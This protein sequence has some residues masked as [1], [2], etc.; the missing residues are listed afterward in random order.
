MSNNAQAG[1]LVAQ[2]WN[3]F[4]GCTKI[5]PGCSHCYAE[6]MAKKLQGWG[7]AGYDR[8]FAFTVHPDRL[9]K[10]PPLRRK[11]PALYFINSMSDTFHEDAD[12]RAIDAILDIVATAHWHNFYFLTKRSARMRAYFDTRQA[13]DNLWLGVTVEDREHGLKRLEDLRKTRCRHRHLCCEPLLEDLGSIDLTGIRLVVGGGESGAHARPADAAW[14]ESL[15]EQCQNQNVDFYWKQ[16][17][18]YDQE[19]RARGKRHS[20]AKVNGRLLQSFPP[21]LMPLR[22]T[23]RT[24]ATTKKAR[25]AP[26]V[27]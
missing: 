20:G 19:G 7:T 21:D 14:V 2:T 16:W 9:D 11:K 12:E 3:P 23:H 4:T 10:A 27:S 18:T 25:I 1:Q 22:N 8:G 15:N 6:V 24:Q 13:P 26:A 5:S 17:G